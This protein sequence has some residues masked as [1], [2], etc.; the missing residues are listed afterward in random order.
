MSKWLLVIG[1][2]PTVFAQDPTLQSVKLHTDPE[3]RR[4]LPGENVVIQA[5]AYGQVAGG[6]TM[7]RIQ[8]PIGEV[9]VAEGGGWISKPFKYQGD[10]KEPILETSSSSWRNIMERALGQYVQKDSVLYTAPEAPGKYLV[11]VAV[12]DLTERVE[13]EV[14]ADARSRR[15]PEKIEFKSIDTSRESYRKLA[16][17]YAPFIAQ[18][19]W[20]TPRADRLTRFDFDGDFKGDNNW[21]NLDEG[22]SQAYVHY[23]AI[24]TATHWFLIYNFFHPRD[25]SDNCIAGSCHE[26][27]NEGLVLTVRKDST[28]FGKLLTMETLAHNNIYSYTS[29]RGIRNGVHDID[30]PIALH[31]GTHPIIFIEAG[32][33]GVL[34][35]DDRKSVFDSGKLDFRQNTGITYIYKG[36]AERPRHSNDRNVGY[37]L[38]PIY[39][40]WWLRT[41]EG[42]DASRTMWNSYFTYV[43]FGNRPR[44][45]RRMIPGSF[46]GRRMSVNKAKPFWG[47]HDERTRKAKVL[48]TGQWGLDPAYSV[49]R[50]LRFPLDEPFS[51]EYTYNPYLGIG[52]TGGAPPVPAFATVVT[53]EPL[54]DALAQA[55]FAPPAAIAPL[56]VAPRGGSCELTVIVDGALDI[57][58][59]GDYPRYELIGGG[60]AQE[61]VEYKCSAP[62]PEG[63]RFRVEKLAGRG[64][65]KLVEGLVAKIHIEDPAGSSD[66]YKLR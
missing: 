47:W 14:T 5:R 51:L 1:L 40:H 39:E 45:Q 34:G 32:G 22:S 4:V 7:G 10:D 42:E 12:A 23:A 52:D 56:A 66:T 49:S 15:K 21:E 57:V 27:D 48:N 24:E 18:E 2:V 20:Y 43:P 35:A 65:V 63:A 44:T 9:K 29:E 55:R 6:E 28:E 33:H 8:V 62:V 59:K 61:E 38:L 19:T 41:Q 26:N 60:R 25:Y 17:R 50:N 36:V 30:G 3:H 53:S 64:A 31:D 13:I 11:E 54:P 16:E 46:L 58:W 37:E